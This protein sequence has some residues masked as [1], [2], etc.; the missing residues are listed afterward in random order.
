MPCEHELC[1]ECFKQNVEEANF[2]CPLCRIRI[3]TWARRSA[4]NKSLVN[5]NRWEEI[6]KQFPEA[7]KRRLE[8]L[9][10][11][12]NDQMVPCVPIKLAKPGEIRSEYED[13]MHKLEQQRA[14][15]ERSAQEATLRL[16]QQLQEEE[17]QKISEQ[18][19]LQQQDEE[20]A[21]LLSQ[22]DVSAFD[23]AS[24][25]ELDT[26]NI[27]STNETPT[28]DIFFNQ[29]SSEGVKS[30]SSSFPCPSPRSSG[31]VKLC[32]DMEKSKEQDN[33]FIMKKGKKNNLLT[34]QVIMGLEESFKR[35]NRKP[36]SC[37]RSDEVMFS[38]IQKDLVQSPACTI[39]SSR[40]SNTS[41]SNDEIL[42]QM[43]EDA[44]LIL[45]DDCNADISV[46]SFLVPESDKV[47][48][49]N[50]TKVS[51]THLIASISPPLVPE[52]RSS[53]ALRTASTQSFDSISEELNH[54]RP[55]LTCPLTPPRR[56]PSGKVVETH[57]IRTTPRNLSCSSHHPAEH[58]DLPDV[59]PTSPIM[60]TRLSQLAEERNN[61]VK[62]MSKSTN[63][64]L[65]KSDENRN[66]ELSSPDNARQRCT[67]LT[68]GT[69]R[70]VN[71]QD[72]SNSPLTKHKFDFLD[73]V[74][75]NCPVKK[76]AIIPLEPDLIENDVFDESLFNAIG[77]MKDLSKGNKGQFSIEHKMKSDQSKTS[78][79]NSQHTLMKWMKPV[80]FNGMKIRCA[81]D[82]M[83]IADRDELDGER[84]LKKQKLDG[85][86][87]SVIVDKASIA[88]IVKTVSAVTQHSRSR[89]C[90]KMHTDPDFIYNSGERTIKTYSDEIGDKLG[91]TDLRLDS[92]KITNDTCK[93]TKNNKHIL[94]FSDGDC[95]AKTEKALMRNC[96]KT[97]NKLKTTKT[98]KRIQRKKTK[99][100]ECAVTNASKTTINDFFTNKC[101]QEIDQQEQDRLYALE[102]Q[103]QFEL[104]NRLRLNALRFTGTK[105]QYSLRKLSKLIEN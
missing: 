53:S 95:I 76:I 26:S 20:L 83:L 69:S 13:M 65:I 57:L 9:E 70:G 40:S 91:N 3:S 37:T 96:N 63:T 42:N 88:K 98:T 24:I 104:E 21:R 6:Q 33:K 50:A 10:D 2:C 71:F 46:S 75:E 44:C 79:S 99:R 48:Q 97:K 52:V 30:R 39:T 90:R 72:I 34:T 5:E 82:D 28:H 43:S 103:R 73:D 12:E 78:I 101:N 32:I 81:H 87:S 45:D 29:N 102:L 17:A 84:D 41:F 86:L 16:I 4:R 47:N 49:K 94:P 67:P 59:D 93:E 25:S 64:T 105:D 92:E 55:I 61:Q 15:E 85:H 54:F 35:N 62:K 1:L 56:L 100:K 31:E 8:G 51:A 19:L 89:R 58:T 18:E 77:N 11:D 38:T 60:R 80:T 74:I 7:V 27:R 36:K 23:I 14:E 66:P 68:N 22:T